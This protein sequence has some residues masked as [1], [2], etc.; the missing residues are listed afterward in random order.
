MKGYDLVSVVLGN[1]CVS[2][3]SHGKQNAGSLS[4]LGSA[5]GRVILAGGFHSGDWRKLRTFSGQVE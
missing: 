1:R 4:T 2:D 5:E 3:G